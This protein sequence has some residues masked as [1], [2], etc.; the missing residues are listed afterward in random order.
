MGAFEGS[1]LLMIRSVSDSFAAMVTGRWLHS[2]AG[3]LF[4]LRIRWNRVSAG[5]HFHSAK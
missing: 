4:V 2:R 3:L 5:V 1:W